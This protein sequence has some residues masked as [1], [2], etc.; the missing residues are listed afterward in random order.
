MSQGRIAE[1]YQGM[2]LN[3]SYIDKCPR[4]RKWGREVGENSC[5]DHIISS[6][7]VFRLY[8]GNGNL[9]TLWNMIW[10]A[11]FLGSLLWNFQ[12]PNFPSLVGYILSAIARC[13][14]E[15]IELTQSLFKWPF[16]SSSI[17]LGDSSSKRFVGTSQQ[18]MYGWLAPP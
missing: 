14:L 4:Q 17:L 7:S 13:W 10:S 2:F 5:Y 8:I 15:S 16:W 1:E 18:P 11:K 12:S 9:T 3:N 6:F